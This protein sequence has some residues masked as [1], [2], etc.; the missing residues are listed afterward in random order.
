MMQ[1]I[2]NRTRRRVVRALENND[3]NSR[4][5]N[6]I[7]NINNIGFANAIDIQRSC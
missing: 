1:R 5:G 3:D 6:M 2:K 4:V 7:H